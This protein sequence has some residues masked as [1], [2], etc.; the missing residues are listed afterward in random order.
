ME[1]RSLLYYDSAIGL[2]PEEIMILPTLEPDAA[3]AV[4]VPSLVV[5]YVVMSTIPEWNTSPIPTPLR[6]P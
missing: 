6:T 2:E 5:K 1:R 4:A 3:I